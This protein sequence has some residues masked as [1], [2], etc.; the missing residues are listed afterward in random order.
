MFYD[1]FGSGT[2][3]PCCLLSRAKGYSRYQI[4]W[5]DTRRRQV[6]TRLHLVT[7]SE[8][9]DALANRVSLA[10]RARRNAVS[11][12]RYNLYIDNM[13]FEGNPELTNGQIFRI[14][15]SALNTQRLFEMEDSDVY[16]ELMGEV[17]SEY[18]RCINKIVFDEALKE[19][20]FRSMLQHLELPNRPQK[21]PAPYLGTIVVPPYQY[22][23]A[24]MQ[25]KDATYNDLGEVIL[26]MHNVRAECNKVLDTALFITDLMKAMEVSV[27]HICL[28]P[29][30]CNLLFSLFVLFRVVLAFLL[31][32][33][34]CALFS[35]DPGFPVEIKISLSRSVGPTGIS[36]HSNRAEQTSSDCAQADVDRCCEEWYL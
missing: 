11:F 30:L 3:K 17:T 8:K 4:E 1:E 32:S 28:L 2:W 18:A 21:T 36:S 7:K 22:G 16:Q 34:A 26:A 10:V 23:S 5:Q 14:K 6:V 20:D 15:G 19:K 31:N 9:I 12:L 25:F 24:S 35:D 27:T 33:R 29:S 13:P